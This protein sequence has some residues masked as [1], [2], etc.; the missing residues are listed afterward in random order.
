MAILLKQMNKTPRNFQ[1]RL[2]DMKHEDDQHQKT[3]MPTL[4]TA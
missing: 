3:Q 4:P 2:T 1:V